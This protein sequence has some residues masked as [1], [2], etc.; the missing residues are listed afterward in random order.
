MTVTHKAEFSLLALR[1]RRSFLFDRRLG[2]CFDRQLGRGKGFGLREKSQATPPRKVVSIRVTCESVSASKR[3]LLSTNGPY[4][5]VPSLITTHP[6][7]RFPFKT[8]LT[9]SACVKPQA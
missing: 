7:R 9:S 6:T 8:A 1:H 3:L 2:R 5:F 4:S